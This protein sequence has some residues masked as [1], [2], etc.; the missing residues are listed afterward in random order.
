MLHEREN[1]PI[2]DPGLPWDGTFK[3]QAAPVEVYAYYIEVE[4]PDGRV[5]QDQGEVSLLR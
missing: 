4:W 5:Q 2:G 1:L 3:G